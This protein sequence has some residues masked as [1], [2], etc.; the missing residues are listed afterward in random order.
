M[1]IKTKNNKLPINIL[2]Y[3][4]HYAFIDIESYNDIKSALPYDISFNIMLGDDIIKKYCLL[5]IDCFEDDDIQDKCYYKDKIPLYEY[6]QHLEENKDI[7]FM[8]LSKYDMCKTLNEIFTRYNIKLI[9]GYNV[10]FDYRVVNRLFTNVN[11]TIR[12][13]RRRH[14]DFKLNYKDIDPLIKNEFSKVNY[15]DLWYGIT[16]LFKVNDELFCQYIEFCLKNEFMTDSYKSISSKED[17]IYKFFIDL[18]HNEWHIGFKDVEDER[19]LYKHFKQLLR[20]RLFNKTQF[21]Q[22]NTTT[23]K[24]VYSLMNVKRVLK[25]FG[26]LELYK[27]KLEYFK[28]LQD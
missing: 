20:T 26:K 9:I 6:Q 23:Q 1:K 21:L 5:F 8:Y 4:K 18:L 17:Y 10:G 28:T 25:K 7:E 12:R 14:K 24:S 27:D 3:K 2:T 11:N 15:F 19:V 16:E 13:R 22:L